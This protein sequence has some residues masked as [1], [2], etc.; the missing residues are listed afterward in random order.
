MHTRTI[1]VVLAVGCTLALAA[2]N[3]RDDKVVTKANNPTIIDKS[4]TEPPGGAVSP[5]VAA[6]A[7]QA[8]TAPTSAKPSAPPAAKVGD[9]LSLTNTKGVPVDV[10]LVKLV[11]PAAS[12][13]QYL[14]PK[15]GNRYVAVQWKIVNSGDQPI[16]DTP[17]Y[18]S[19]LIDADGQQF[20]STYSETSAGPAF[21]SSV[22]IPPGGSR[23]GFVTYEVPTDSKITTIQLQISMMS[24]NTGQWNV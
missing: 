19:H 11:D 2:C 16:T 6:P 12:S 8:T 23:L 9:T 24:T 5:T 14:K 7:G 17:N 18:G 13:N 21:P 3:G 15:A 4:V 22:S 1:G 20:S 10:T